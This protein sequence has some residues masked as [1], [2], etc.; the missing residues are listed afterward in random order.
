MTIVRNAV[1]V[2]VFGV[3]ALA[4]AGRAQT[5][6]QPQDVSLQ[7]ELLKDW[8]D[9]KQTMRKIAAE[10]PADKYHVD[11]PRPNRRLANGWFTSR[12]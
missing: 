2:V 4:G 3:T 12:R 11:R 6:A 10:M 7:A 8:S 5:P 1:V 9:L